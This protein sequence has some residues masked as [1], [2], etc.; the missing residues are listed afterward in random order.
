MS[1]EKARK[2]DDVEG[3]VMIV[4]DKDGREPSTRISL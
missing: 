2:D 1:S 4:F 3:G